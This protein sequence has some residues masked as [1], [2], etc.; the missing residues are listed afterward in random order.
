MMARQGE[1]IPPSS[2]YRHDDFSVRAIN[3]TE[4]EPQ[5]GMPIA[6]I[7]SLEQVVTP[8]H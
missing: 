1:L 6:S 4:G 3:M 5:M 7:S 8:G 2:C